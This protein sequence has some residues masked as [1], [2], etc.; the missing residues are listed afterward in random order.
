MK[1][2]KQIK[3]LAYL[4]L[5]ITVAFMT[6]SSMAADPPRHRAAAIYAQVQYAGESDD[7]LLFK[8]KLT[9]EGDSSVKHIEVNIFAANPDEAFTETY[10]L[11]KTETIFKVKKA[12]IEK[13]SFCIVT[14]G[15]RTYFYF[16]VKRTYK[17]EIDVVSSK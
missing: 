12:D 10:P 2:N 11:S 8:V 1:T 9:A 4:L 17:E 16:D 15:K 5:M 7:Y 3:K 6:K 14:R 13:I